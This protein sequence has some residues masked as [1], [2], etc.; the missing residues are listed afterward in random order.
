MGSDKPQQ[1]PPPRRRPSQWE[2]VTEDPTRELKPNNQEK[3]REAKTPKS[4]NGDDREL[5]DEETRRADEGSSGEEEN[6]D[7]VDEDTEDNTE[8]NKILRQRREILQE[9][10]AGKITEDT[11]KRENRKELEKRVKQCLQDGDDGEPTLLHTMVI[12]IKFNAIQ[13][14]LAYKSLA[15]LA[16]KDNESLMTI[17]A[18]TTEGTALHL[19]IDKG[20]GDFAQYLCR[21]SK[22]AAAAIRLKRK[23]GY[24]C[25]RLAF[26]K[27]LSTL[28][29]I[30]KYADNELFKLW[31]GAGNT[32][33]HE[34]VDFGRCKGSQ[35]KIVEEVYCKWPKA[36]NELNDAGQSPYQY[37][38]HTKTSK[39]VSQKNMKDKNSKH[40]GAETPTAETLVYIQGI[41]TSRNE[42]TEK[43]SNASSQN[44][45]V[46]KS[47]SEEVADTVEK[48][49]KEKS[50]AAKKFE[51]AVMCIF[52]STK[53][54]SL[55]SRPRQSIQI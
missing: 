47:P 17:G 54:M 27:G 39:R 14:L 43:G 15:K 32:V 3:K 49:L 41:L 22:N 42:I 29:T 25:L 40:R 34:V 10:T 16:L 4:P 33:L 5:H 26:E 11:F 50:L 31:S 20:L 8:V 13:Q 12:Y 21:A 6:E 24:N 48:F 30:V 55:F 44:R 52:G 1:M 46:K 19:A 35:K 36:I 9:I 51:D 38:L 18:D 2:N 7:D 28:L 53:S 23:D 37:H 45:A